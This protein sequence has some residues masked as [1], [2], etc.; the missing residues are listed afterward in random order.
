MELFERGKQIKQE[1]EEKKR[2]SAEEVYER[3][4]M[5][6]RRMAVATI[7]FIVMIEVTVSS[8]LAYEIYQND[9]H[10]RVLREFEIRTSGEIRLSTGTYTGETDFGYFFGEGNFDFDSGA[11]YTGSWSDNFLSGYGELRVPINGIYYGDFS[12]SQK[13]GNGVFSWDDG[14]IYE[15][16]W[17]ADQ[18]VGQGV[19][20]GADGVIYTGTFKNN[21]LY[22]GNCTFENETGTYCLAYKEGRVC[23]AVINFID[24]SEYSGGADE[25][26][27]NG[28]GQMTFANQDVYNGGFLNGTREGY[29]TYT[30]V[31]G[32]RYDG[33]WSDDKMSGTGIYTFDDGSILDGVFSNNSFIDGS[34]HVINDFGDYTFTQLSQL[35][36]PN[37]A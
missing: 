22:K 35:I 33:E 36:F 29:G 25:N 15:G 12:F 1:M 17:N 23:N 10:N 18:M 9:F 7:A 27:L 14:S 26:T 34:Y 8:G 16:E 30:W 3:A 32:D 24:G 4:K 19:Y 11:S 31:F 2:F 21:A 5:A 20:T 37:K 13:S 6:K 28:D